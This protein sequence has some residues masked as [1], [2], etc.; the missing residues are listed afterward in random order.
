MKSLRITEKGGVLA[1][2]LASIAPHLS[3]VEDSLVAQSKE[4]DPAVEE[5][6]LRGWRS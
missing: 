3:K 2:A 5:L 6:V 1:A 4:V